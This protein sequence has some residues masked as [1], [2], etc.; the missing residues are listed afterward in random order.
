MILHVSDHRR[1]TETP[2]HVAFPTPLGVNVM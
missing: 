2:T 1:A